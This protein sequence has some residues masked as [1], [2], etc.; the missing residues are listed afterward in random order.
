MDAINQNEG[1]PY[2]VFIDQ[3]RE[4]VNRERREQ[5]VVSL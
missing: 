1:I 4:E 3:E 5:L 2:Q